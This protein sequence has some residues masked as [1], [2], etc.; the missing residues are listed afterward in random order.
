MAL[1]Y[2]GTLRAFKAHKD[3]LNGAY[4]EDSVPAAMAWIVADF[5]QKKSA[6]DVDTARRVMR[7]ISGAFFIGGTFI[8]TTGLWKG[9][10]SGGLALLT[11]R[12]FFEGYTEEGLYAFQD[13]ARAAAKYIAMVFDQDSVSCVVQ[14]P[15]GATRV[16]FVAQGAPVNPFGEIDRMIDADDYNFPPK[17]KADAKAKARATLARAYKLARSK[18]LP[19]VTNVMGD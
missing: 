3:S 10:M 12:P 18:R 8:R 13:L 9:D 5:S 16:E 15:S 6:F 7:D 4:R 17:E 1:G 19:G 11:F 2:F 14:S